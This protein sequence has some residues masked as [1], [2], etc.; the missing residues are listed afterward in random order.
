MLVGVAACTLAAIAGPGRSSGPAVGPGPVSTVVVQGGYRVAVSITPNK[1]GLVFN[2]FTIRCTR[3]GRQ[4]LGTVTARFTMVAM[5]MPSLSLTLRPVAPGV[6]RATGRTLTMPGRW[7]IRFRIGPRGA[8]PFTLTVR[9][10][11]T[12]GLL[13]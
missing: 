8:S 6:Y 13:Q 4:V 12:L 2:T 9:D 5:P 11:A 1:A 7:E 10:H 3:G